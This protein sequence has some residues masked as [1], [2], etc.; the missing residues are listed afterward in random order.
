MSIIECTLPEC[1]HHKSQPNSFR[2]TLSFFSIN[3]FKIKS[4]KGKTFQSKFRFNTTLRSRNGPSQTKEN[5]VVL[6]MKSSESLF[7]E[8]KQ[9]IYQR[10][11][12]S[13]KTIEKDRC[14]FHN[15]LLKS[16]IESCRS[17]KRNINV[18]KENINNKIKIVKISK[19]ILMST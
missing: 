13:N 18:S 1:Y 11:V 15:S 2:G 9:T 7:P 14:I 19:L 17:L 6:Q 16:T 3:K 10:F 5:R 4:Q 12:G 8:L